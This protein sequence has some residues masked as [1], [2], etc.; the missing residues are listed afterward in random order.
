LR[1][2]DELRRQYDQEIEIP[3]VIGGQAITTGK[4]GK[5]TCPHDRGHVLAVY[6]RAGKKEAKLAIEAAMASRQRWVD[7]DWSQRAAVFLKMADLISTKYRYV[8][9]AATMLG[10]SKTAFQAEIESACEMADFLRFNVKQAED[11]HTIQPISTRRV[12]NRLAYR[13]LEGF[14][15]AVTPFNFTAIAGNLATAPAVMGNT[16][17]WKPSSRSLLSNYYLMQ[18]FMEAGLPEGVINFIPG[19]GSDI[20][21]TVLADQR[22]AG[23]NFTG[24]TGTFQSL[25][26]EIARN[27]THYRNYPRIVGETGGK[28]YVFMHASGGVAETAAAIVRAGFEYQGQKCSA[29]SRVYVPQSQW[30]DL[31]TALLSM[32]SQI[33]VGSVMDFS[34]FM[35]AVIDERAFEN[36]M[37]YI[38]QAASSESTEIIAGGNGDKSSG[39]YIDPTL[40][41]TSDPKFV[42]M[43]EE[44][45]GPVVTVYVY[46]DHAYAD[47]LDLCDQT[48][49][50]G[51]TGS[52]FARD[53]A[54]IRLAEKKLS[55]T[56][57]NFYINDKPSG[58][59]VGQQPF[60]GSRASGT[61]DKAGSHLNLIRWTSPRTIKENFSPPRD[62]RYAFMD[63][64]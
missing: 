53:R 16:V 26:L 28:G 39:Y 51:L 45:F 41:V 42:T 5:I 56:A 2:K 10:Q 29:C 3:L 19:S 59:V 1:L 35:N 38:R 6:H 64:P 43:Q 44:I 63:E 7:L 25:W 9:N 17:V 24:S 58:A 23:L 52:I 34:N 57:G 48:S 50:Y 36:I 47:T 37:G 33:K 13:P 61:N 15:F 14:V 8:L 32:I 20:G 46:D 60:G 4:T 27:I 11:I 62:F 21:S 49:P 55:H 18:L 12:W 31:K 30:Q 40:V 54:A 22:L